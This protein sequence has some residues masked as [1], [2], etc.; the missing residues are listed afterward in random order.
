[1]SARDWLQIRTELGEA[2]PG[3]RGRR[4]APGTDPD[5]R[6]VSPVTVEDSMLQ[7]IAEALRLD[8][9]DAD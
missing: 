9:A 5:P 8:E 1:M 4:Q 7:H 6:A 3:E 2:T